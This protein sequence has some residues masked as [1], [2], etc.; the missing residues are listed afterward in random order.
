MKSFN[1]YDFWPYNFYR[2]TKFVRIL[3]SRLARVE[4]IISVKR[5][6]LTVYVYALCEPSRLCMIGP[7]GRAF[8][9]SVNFYQPNA[10]ADF[11]RQFERLR[12]GAYDG[13]TY[14]RQS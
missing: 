7:I 12:M 6:G 11:W 10:E 5:Q 8:L 1:Y 3:M 14:R 4:G 2:A 13:T 9:I